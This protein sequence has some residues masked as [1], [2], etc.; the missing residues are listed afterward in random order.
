MLG[1]S[2]ETYPIDDARSFGLGIFGRERELGIVCPRVDRC[3]PD[4][5]HIWARR[6][7]AFRVRKKSSGV[8]DIPTPSTLAISSQLFRPSTVSI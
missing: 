8:G 4:K 7:R 5:Q 1:W 6:Q 3:L 2:L